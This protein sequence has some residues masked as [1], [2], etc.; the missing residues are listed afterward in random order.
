MDGLET[1]VDTRDR[2][3][4]GLPGLEAEEEVVPVDR[5]HFGNEEDDVVLHQEGADRRLPL[6]CAQ[7]EGLCRNRLRQDLRVEVHADGLVDG[8]A[9]E[10]ATGAGTTQIAARHAK[11]DTGLAAG[12]CHLFT[13]SATAG[14]GCESERSS[15]GKGQEGTTD[16]VLH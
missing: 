12:C 15:K 8:D 13:R 3:R 1:A 11:V 9:R 2:Q 10:C 14:T 16:Q 7:L 4:I 6:G 5:L